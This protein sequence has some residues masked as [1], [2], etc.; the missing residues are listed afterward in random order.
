M[1]LAPSQSLRH[2]RR[3]ALMAGRSADPTR[4]RLGV[5]NRSKFLQILSRLRCDWPAAGVLL[6]TSFLSFI[7]SLFHSSFF[8]FYPLLSHFA[9]LSFF[10]DSATLPGA[11]G[12]M[13]LPLGDAGQAASCVHASYPPPPAESGLVLKS[14]WCSQGIPPPPPAAA[15]RKTKGNVTSC[16]CHHLLIFQKLC[17]P[18]KILFCFCFCFFSV[19]VGDAVVPSVDGNDIPALG[20]LMHVSAGC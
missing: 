3:L 2:R 5:Q 14:N 4:V 13:F 7:L 1:L 15:S 10:S 19:Y 17:K 12:L 16:K 9:L 6:S 11:P 8:F 20:F 18:P